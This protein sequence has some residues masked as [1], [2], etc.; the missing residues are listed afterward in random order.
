M[1]RAA[2][3]RIVETAAGPFEQRLARQRVAVLAE[4][5]AGEADDD[6]TGAHARGQDAGALDNA[7]GKADEVELARLHDVVLRHLAAEQRASG[8]AATVRDAGHD[9]GDDLLDQLAGRDV[10]EEEER[11]GALHGDV[12]DGARDEVDADRVVLPHQSA[13]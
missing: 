8:G 9:V 12:V 3:R 5:G 7:D 11:L 2:P 6:V 1:V 10:V 4:P 13:R